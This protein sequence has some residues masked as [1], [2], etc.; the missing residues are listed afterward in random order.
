MQSPVRTDHRKRIIKIRKKKAVPKGTAFNLNHLI[1]ILW[2]VRQCVCGQL[3][4][5][6]QLQHEHG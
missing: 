3:P 6:E 1:L 2:Q 4:D 5:A